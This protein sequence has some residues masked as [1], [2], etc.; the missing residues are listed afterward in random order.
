MAA[1]IT[2]MVVLACQ[3][4]FFWTQDRR[5]SWLAWLIVPFALGTAAMV[6][7]MLRWKEQDYLANGVSYALIV[8]SFGLIWQGLRVFER[9][10]LLIWPVV[11][12][13]SG[14]LVLCLWPEFLDSLPSRIALLSALVAGYCGL[15]VA[16]LRRGREERLPSR[17]PLTI[18]LSSYAAFMVLRIALVGVAP[19]PFGGQPL[20][21]GW[22]GIFNA[23]VFAHLMAMAVFMVSLTKERRELQQRNDALTDPLTG[24]LNR[25]AFALQAQRVH[26][27]GKFGRRETSVLALDLDHFKRVNDR[28]GHHA[29]DRVLR[30]FA[31]ISEAVL[32]TAGRLYRVGGEEFCFVLADTALAEAIELAERI[33][34]ETEL[35]LVEAGGEEIRVT[36]SIG[37]ATASFAGFD[38]EVLRGAADA[39]LYEAKARGRNRVVVAEPTAIPR[40]VE[41]IGPRRLS[42]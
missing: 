3:L 42:A 15:G 26:Y 37:I 8:A 32:G 30:E 27:P 13:V 7:L 22:I 23:I 29:G 28:F 39:A 10:P 11:G 1:L 2:V 25:R 36:V 14:W 17:L 35:M 38:L 19:Y 40:P 41:R 5:S 9:Q 6:I 18:V 4:L 24:L 21:P 31:R 16:E 33:R 34:G 12:T 20:Q